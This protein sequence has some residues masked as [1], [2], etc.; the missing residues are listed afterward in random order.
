MKAILEGVLPAFCAPGVV[1]EPAGRPIS[2]PS[3]SQSRWALPTLAD[4]KRG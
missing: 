1:D 4:S 2:R 3:L